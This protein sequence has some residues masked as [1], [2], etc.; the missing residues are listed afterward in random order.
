MFAPLPTSTK[1]SHGGI[2]RCLSQSIGMLGQLAIHLACMVYIAELAKVAMGEDEV[3]A[4]IE[5]EKAGE[6]PHRQRLEF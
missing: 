5:F 6:G 4:V 2:S 1:Y 3:K